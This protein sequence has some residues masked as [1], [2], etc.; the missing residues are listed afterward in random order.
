MTAWPHGC[1]VGSDQLWKDLQGSLKGL[2]V[3]DP[4]LG[5][6]KG[7]FTGMRLG[8]LKGVPL[9]APLRV[10]FGTPLRTPLRE[11]QIQNFGIQGWE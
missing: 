8:A 7:S 10:P 2:G 9:R 6:F 1:T 3:R 11:A 5:S 4:L